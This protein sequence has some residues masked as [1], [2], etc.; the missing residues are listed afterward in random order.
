MW[1]NSFMKSGAN[2]SMNYLLIETSSKVIAIPKFYSRI[3]EKTSLLLYWIKYKF[4]AVS[5]IVPWSSRTGKIIINNKN[6]K[7]VYVNADRFWIKINLTNQDT[8]SMQPT[9]V[10]AKIRM[11]QFTVNIGITVTEQIYLG[12]SIFWDR[13]MES[14]VTVRK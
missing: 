7:S 14:V 2:I 12:F 6:I 13:K 4:C 9:K 5:Q 10:S 1:W 8:R 3:G 11:K